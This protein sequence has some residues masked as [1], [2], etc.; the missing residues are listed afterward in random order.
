[1]AFRSNGYYWAQNHDIPNMTMFEDQVEQP[2]GGRAKV[3][4]S[5]F[6]RT[7]RAVLEGEVDC[8]LA[9]A[10]EF[11]KLIKKKG[12]EDQLVITN[13]HERRMVVDLNEVEYLY[14]LGMVDLHTPILLGNYYDTLPAQDEPEPCT[15]G[16]RDLQPH[17]AGRT[18]LPSGNARQEEPAS[19]RR[20]VL[21]AA[22]LG[23]DDRR[24]GRD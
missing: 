13:L 15:V 22:R 21:S 23:S 9:N 12:L 11:R 20:Q 4:E 19:A 2:E 14:N 17:P 7:L 10:I 5:A 18:A 16:S 6:D 3:V 8:T 1:M 24:R